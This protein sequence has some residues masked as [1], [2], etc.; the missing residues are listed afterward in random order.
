MDGVVGRMDA[1]VSVREIDIDQDPVLCA[2]FNDDVPVIFIG[3]RKR[4]KHRV[5]A[6]VLEK[7]L[8]AAMTGRGWPRHPLGVF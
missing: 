7:H 5:D 3:G 1:T 4:F 6:A 8:S 2:E